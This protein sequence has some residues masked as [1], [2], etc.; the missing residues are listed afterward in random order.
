[1]MK[2]INI[3]AL[4][5]LAF[6]ATLLA[7]TL[8]LSTEESSAAVIQRGSVSCPGAI[9]TVLV[10]DDTGAVL[11]VVEVQVPSGAT[12]T[13]ISNPGIPVGMFGTGSTL[14][15]QVQGLEV[16]AFGAGHS[17]INNGN[18]PF[19][20]ME[21]AGAR[22]TNNETGTSGIG[23][24]GAVGFVVIGNDGQVDNAGTVESSGLEAIGIGIQGDLARVNN[25]GTAKASGTESLAI[26]IE[27][28]SGEID[29][30]GTV[31]ATGTEAVAAFIEGSDATITNSGTARATG[32]E[33][34]VISIEGDNATITNTGTGTVIVDGALAGGLTVDGNNAAITNFNDIT[35][36]GGA[37]VAMG[38]FGD[39]G[40]LTNSGDIRTSGAN[41][42]GIAALG[43]RGSLDRG[44]ILTNTATGTIA[45]DGGG[46]HGIVLGLEDL[47][48]I[49]NGAD[50]PTDALAPAQG[51]IFN[52]GTITTSGAGAD[53]IHAFANNSD[54]TS[55][56]RITTTR[57]DADGI[58][59]IG[60]NLDVLQQGTVNTGGSLASGV[61]VVGNSANV[62]NEGV[63]KTMGEQSAAIT[64]RG[65]DAR[66]RNGT[67]DSGTISLID[68]RGAN[69]AGIE[70]IGDGALIDNL[71]DVVTLG[72]VGHGIA[73]NGDDA[74]LV[75][76]S[77]GASISTGG[78]FAS[79]MFIE[80]TGGTYLNDGTIVTA[81]MNAHGMAVEGDEVTL[82]NRGEG[83]ITTTGV[84]AHG[85][86]VGS[87]S[88]GRAV[89]GNVVRNGNQIVTLGQ[90]ADGI[91][92]VGD[93]NDI[94]VDRAGGEDEGSRS[95]STFGSEAH[96]VELNGNNNSL[97][98]GLDGT[99]TA[100]GASS[101]GVNMIGTNDLFNFGTIEA[102]AS[103]A[104]AVQANTEANG[105]IDFQ[106]IMNHGTLRS[107]TNAIVG[108]DLIEVVNNFDQIEGNVTLMGGDDRLGLAPESTITGDADLGDG[109]DGVSIFKDFD[110]VN[111]ALLRGRID[112]NLS[113]GDGDDRLT[114]EGGDHIAGNVLGGMG[115][116]SLIMNASG[117]ETLNGSQF[118]EFEDLTMNVAGLTAVTLTG[119]LDVDHV[120]A[121][122]GGLFSIASGA[123]LD[124][125]L[126]QYVTGTTLG[127]NGTIRG[128]VV[129]ISQAAVNA[130]GSIGELLLDAELLFADSILEVEIGGTDPGE[131]DV[132]RVM[133]EA[134]FMGGEIALNFLNDFVP[135]VG[136]IFDFLVADM[137]LG[138]DTL[139]I[140]Q[141]GLPSGF[142]F[143]LNLTA[144]GLR[145]VTLADTAVPEPPSVLLFGFGGLILVLVT[146]RR[147]PMR[148]TTV[149]SRNSCG[150]FR[151]LQCGHEMSKSPGVA[152]HSAPPVLRNGSRLQGKSFM[153]QGGSTRPG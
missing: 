147:R 146:R 131:F 100:N 6:A 117:L 1:M 102:K 53:G 90:F 58:A 68:V 52:R 144:S 10:D 4:V 25:S 141:G 44:Q 107:P 70:V 9:D 41:A 3:E 95:I 128:D 148:N 149:W 127:G 17:I 96:G 121:T 2:R 105:I 34:E 101:N 104:A 83:S 110:P 132:L 124:A 49:T 42:L 114:I 19:V 5:R 125:T 77:T 76:N 116:D 91:H 152:I 65:N 57:N 62:G 66:V 108:S 8:I 88:L 14:I 136:D 55:N 43:G 15:N 138:L 16:N 87:E 139:T 92:V 86:A 59:G 84:D 120:L 45:T 38:V 64:V 40:I 24:Q 134:N 39:D 145:L 72:Q 142:D 48:D 126:T 129:E 20:I 140:S 21:G 71:K 80:G 79:G 119:T 37:L 33:A 51:S 36:T 12:A 111:N 109:N 22:I 94:T 23:G 56:G 30:S 118:Q 78:E 115:A 123:V 122:G 61:E 113:L 50:L 29:N 27:G 150:Y 11:D 67:E 89:T 46:A 93:G 98:L 69:A 130:G 63:I 31:E 153:H 106:V 137:I 73:V 81:G 32:T 97:T 112:G 18:I 75:T 28:N 143:G 54:I 85:I 103:D 151:V 47:A 26:G 60:F 35:T 13:C 133:G 7:T 74:I 82:V 135:S 99:I